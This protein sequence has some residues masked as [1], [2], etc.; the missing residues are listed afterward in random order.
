M[1]TKKI[2]NIMANRYNECL[3]DVQKNYA[4][5]IYFEGTKI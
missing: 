5:G 2:K 1:K 4:Q 3:D